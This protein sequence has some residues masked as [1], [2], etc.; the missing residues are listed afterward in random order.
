M[1]KTCVSPVIFK[2]FRIRCCVQTRSS[3]PS[4]AR[5]RLRAPTSTPRPVESRNPTLSRLTTSWV[6]ARADQVDEQL[7]QPRRRIHIDLALHADDLDAVLGVVT[8]L[9]IHTSSSAMPGVIAASIPAPRAGVVRAGAGPLPHSATFHYH[10]H[11][12]CS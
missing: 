7:P 12:E 1:P 9:Q 6:A 5:T 11:T 10:A 3:E 8:Q 4:W 2:I